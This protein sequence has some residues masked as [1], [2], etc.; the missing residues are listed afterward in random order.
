[1]PKTK[2]PTTNKNST[3]KATKGQGLDFLKAEILCLIIYAIMFLIGCAVCLV[4]D[5]DY[6]YDY[7]I[8]L[9]IFTISSFIA[10]FIGGIKQK[11]RGII[12]GIIYALPGNFTAII[13]SLILNSF[14]ADLRL[15]LSVAIVI[16]ASGVGGVFAVNKR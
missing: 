4:L 15:A 14:S 8:C 11:Q 7:Y 12:L 9:T 3:K 5:L 6:K 10:G 2:T 13:L 1:M 16:I